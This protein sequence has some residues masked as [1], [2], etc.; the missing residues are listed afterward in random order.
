MTF[1]RRKLLPLCLPGIAARLDLLEY[2][3]AGRLRDIRLVVQDARDG[4]H[5]YAARFCDVNDGGSAQFLHEIST[6]EQS[7]AL[8]SGNITGQRSMFLSVCQHGCLLT[9]AAK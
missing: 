9:T 5:R 3:F 6:K 4:R 2:A 8:R 7:S 1:P